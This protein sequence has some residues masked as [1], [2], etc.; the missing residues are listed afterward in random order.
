LYIA[1][2]QI[3]SRNAVRQFSVIADYIISTPEDMPEYL[4]TNVFA[5]R[6]PHECSSRYNITMTATA[7]STLPPILNALEYFSVISTANVA[8]FI[9]DGMY[10]YV[11]FYFGA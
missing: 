10:T 9:D 4:V 5:N 2:L 3:L 6:E 8:T 7:N 11:E 1:E